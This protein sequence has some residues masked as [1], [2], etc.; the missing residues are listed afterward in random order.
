LSPDGKIPPPLPFAEDE[1]R[2]VAALYRG[3]SSTGSEPTESW[4][5]QHA[6]AADVIHLATHGYFNPHRSTSSGLQLALPP[7]SS[8]TNHSDDDGALQAWEVFS[9]HLGADLVVLSA[10]E[11]GVGSKVPGEGLVGLTRAFQVAGASS[12][13]A[14]QWR[15]ADRSTATA[16]VSFHRALLKGLAKDEALRQAMRT[17][18]GDSATAD[19]R[20]WAPFVLVGGYDP[21]RAGARE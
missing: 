3:R 9:M 19:P 10:C 17:L 21:L 18:A 15:V 7:R 6:N 14:T 8:P 1:A 12:I 11:T 5:R 16:M 13:V 4:F 20:F 2:Q